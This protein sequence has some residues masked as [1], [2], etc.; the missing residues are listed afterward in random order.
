M[1]LNVEMLLELK[2]Y[3]KQQIDLKDDFE[4]I[5]KCFSGSI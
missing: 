2:E 5:G 3:L 1:D 4:T